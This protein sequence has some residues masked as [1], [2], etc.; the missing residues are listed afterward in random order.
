MPTLGPPL[1]GRAPKLLLAQLLSVIQAPCLTWIQ[2]QAVFVLQALPGNGD[3][4]LSQEITVLRRG[5][6][7]GEEM[8][9]TRRGGGRSPC[10]GLTRSPVPTCILR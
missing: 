5:G 2:L 3:H 10:P 9:R 4:E 1:P 6:E 8:R 7:G